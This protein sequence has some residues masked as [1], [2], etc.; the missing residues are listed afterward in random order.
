MAEFTIRLL[1]NAA[2]EFTGMNLTPE[3]PVCLHRRRNNM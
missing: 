3:L 2:G 1:K